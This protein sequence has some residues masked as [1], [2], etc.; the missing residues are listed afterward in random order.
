[1]VTAEEMKLAKDALDNVVEGTSG[2]KDAEK[3]IEK[4]KEYK[5]SQETVKKTGNDILDI[6]KEVSAANTDVAGLGDAAVWNTISNDLYVL[7]KGVK[8]EIKADL[9]S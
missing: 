8:F 5:V 3:A 2:N 1:I 4:A 9:S 6:I 7:H